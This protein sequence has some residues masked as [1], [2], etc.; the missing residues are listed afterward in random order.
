MLHPPYT[1]T[2][3]QVVSHMTDTERVM[4]YR[5][6]SVARGE[7]QMLP[8]FDEN[9]YAAAS[10]ANELPMTA[11]L[12]E[13]LAV[14]DASITLLRN[15]PASVAMHRGNMNG[16]P[17]SVRALAYVIAGHAEHHLKILQE[18]LEP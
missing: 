10:N 8:E 6:L 2:A 9:A 3:K 12:A 5:L 1:W 11:V 14:R 16:T 17:M 18:R 4:A 13:L 15:L 7:R